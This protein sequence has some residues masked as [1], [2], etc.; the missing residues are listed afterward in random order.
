MRYGQ[1]ARDPRPGEEQTYTR[2]F[3][4]LS[5]RDSTVPHCCWVECLSV[6]ACISSL[7]RQPCFIGTATLCQSVSWSPSIVGEINGT[8]GCLAVADIVWRLVLSRGAKTLL[9][10]L[11]GVI[12]KF[13]CCGNIHLFVGSTNSAVVTSGSNIGEL[14]LGMPNPV[15]GGMVF[16]ATRSMIGLGILFGTVVTR[17]IE[18]G[19]PP[20]E[21]VKSKI[22]GMPIPGTTE[23]FWRGNLQDFPL[24][25]PNPVTGMAFGAPMSR[26]ILCNS[27]IGSREI[28]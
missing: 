10:L 28:L 25:M 22:L 16:C 21:G 11:R 9:R 12:N 7:F 5:F 1:D 23:I 14:L 18:V 6:S 26:E 4:P 27:A 24:G 17:E 13:C 2:L 19:M 3:P 20:L 15:T 8:P